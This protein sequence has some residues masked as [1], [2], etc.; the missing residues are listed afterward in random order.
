MLPHGLMKVISRLL[1]ELVQQKSLQDR[2]LLD[3][4]FQTFSRAK[5]LAL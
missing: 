4:S 3:Y 2:P 5:G 1:V